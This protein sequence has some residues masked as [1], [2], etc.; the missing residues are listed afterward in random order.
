MAQASERLYDRQVATLVASWRAYARH[1]DGARVEDIAGAA[2]CLFPSVPES[3]VYNNALLP[4]GLD[5][6]RAGE[7]V[8]AIEEAY[9]KAGIPSYAIWAHESEDEAVAALAARGLR[10][11]TSTRAMAMS[12]DGHSLPRPEI[13]LADLDW[14]TYV[15]RFL[16]IPGLL[17][18]ASPEE[19]HLRVARLDGREV[20]AVIAYDHEGDR[21]VFNL[22]TLPDARRR[23]VGT[24]LTALLLH[25]ARERGCTTASLQSTPIA[26]G[27][28]AALG[29]ADLGR[30]L[31]YAPAAGTFTPPPLRE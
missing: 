1:S 7:V 3:G 8:G 20:G 17:R 13:E 21:G 12:L 11:D 30:Y 28:Y 25:E 23:G 26:E 22:G 10:L 9:G 27:V 4:R 24:A 31:E 15:E 18:G 14:A 19:F 16:E 5:A 29:F 2:V 6:G